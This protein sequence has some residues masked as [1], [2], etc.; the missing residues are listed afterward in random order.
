MKE[1]RQLEV[2]GIWRINAHGAATVGGGSGGKTST[3]VLARDQRQ[4]VV[5][6]KATTYMSLSTS[7]AVL[8]LPAA[9]SLLDAK[10]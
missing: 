9:V 10:L 1:T 8:H 3:V 6:R 4:A 7:M 2:G 5:G